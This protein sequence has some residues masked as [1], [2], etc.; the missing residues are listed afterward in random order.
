MGLFSQPKI[1]KGGFEETEA[2]VETYYRHR[3]LNPEQY[4]LDSSDGT[5]W[6]LQEGSAQIYIVIQEGEEGIGSLLRISSPLVY[7]P[8]Q[9]KESF[10]RRLLDL[11]SNLTHCALA[12]YGDMVMVLSQRPSTG[13]VQEELD[14]WVWNTAYIADLL[15][16]KLIEEFG[17]RPYSGA[18]TTNARA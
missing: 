8:E 14:E 12:T 13:L 3:G 2:M 17:A 1:N 11:N 7:V 5:G 6:W 10:Y 4:R 18:S 9:N 15:D 16:D